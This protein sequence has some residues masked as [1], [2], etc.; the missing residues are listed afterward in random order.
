MAATI[1]VWQDNQV[2][3]VNAA[4]VNGFKNENN[5]LILTAGGTLDTGNN[6]Q[7]AQ[8]VSTYAGGGSYYRDSGVPN[9]YALSPVDNRVPPFAYSEGMRVSFKPANSN[10]G[11][12]TV[13]L[14]SLGVKDLKLPNG[15]PTPANSVRS[16]ELIEIY[17][18]P[19]D[20][21]RIVG[22][23]EFLSGGVTGQMRFGYF[24]VANPGWILYSDGSIGNSGSG[25]TILADP[26]A[27]ALY[28]RFY[29]LVENS[30][31]PVDGGRT[32]NAANDF[33]ANKALF[34]PRIEGRAIGIAGGPEEGITLRLLGEF[35]GGESFSLTIDQLPPHAHG[36][37]V[38]TAV[39][40]FSPGFQS[41]GNRPFAREGGTV[42]TTASTGGG[43]PYP[44]MQPTSFINAQ[45]KL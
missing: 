34:L 29:N 26:S 33:D 18:D 6:N 20:E 40:I 14:G 31:A 43:Q 39:D 23:Y 4:D 8:A 27:F 13:N 7:T 16:G 21:F 25:A 17:F 12:S 2:P 37:D 24:T 32:G 5:R 45:I 42:T 15:D 38:T 11:P 41:G 1:K 44:V 19:A 36:L 10:T 28:E 30:F 22:R 9:Q 3:Q 35:I